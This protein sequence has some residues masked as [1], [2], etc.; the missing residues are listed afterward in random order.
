VQEDYSYSYLSSL[1]AYHKR[2]L[3]ARLEAREA[4]E[5]DEGEELSFLLSSMPDSPAIAT[6]KMSCLKK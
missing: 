3:F 6:I 2:T 5:N 4:E 1:V